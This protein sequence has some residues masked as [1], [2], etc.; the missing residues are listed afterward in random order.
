[1]NRL[2]G[3]SDLADRLP[4]SLSKIQEMAKSGDIPMIVFSGSRK[5]VI[6]ESVFES[7]LQDVYNNGINRL[8]KREAVCKSDEL[9]PKHNT[10]A[11]I[12]IHQAGFGPQNRQKLG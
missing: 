8:D 6:L 2:L 1:M 5:Y 7:W 10:Q 4:F 9:S 12:V 3:T 11:G